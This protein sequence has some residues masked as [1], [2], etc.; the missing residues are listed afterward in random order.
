MHTGQY[1][2]SADG[3]GLRLALRDMARFYNLPVNMWGLSS[4]SQEID[5]HYGHEATANGLLAY[6][7]G[8]DLVGQNGAGQSSGSSDCECGTAGPS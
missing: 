1:G 3:L 2:N 6:L 5:A 4:D 7:A 8:A